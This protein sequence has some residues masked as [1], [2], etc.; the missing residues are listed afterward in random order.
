VL[1]EG[2]QFHGRPVVSL[3]DGSAISIGDRTL[4]CSVSEST[5]LGVNHPVV[6]RT[7]LP[8]A[9]IEIAEDVGVSGGS[10]CATIEVSIGPG[11]LLGANV[12]IADT[13]FHPLDHPQRRHAPIPAPED[14]DRVRIGS[15][16]FLG[17][18]AIV[19]KGSVIEDNAVV[20]AGAV[21]SGHVP[22]GARVAGPSAR[23]L[24]DA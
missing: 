14:A 16:V 7:L 19:L 23:V 11:T 22:R 12:T 21:I 20:G 3:A 13:D 6:L 1:G 2:V 8:G 9:R 5:A 15:N 4:V 17:T 24:S 18:G 10:I